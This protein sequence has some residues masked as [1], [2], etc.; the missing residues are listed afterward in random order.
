[1]TLIIETRQLS[2]IFYE[3]QANEV[4][5]VQDISLSVEKGQAVLLKG[6]SGSGKSTLLALLA[7][8]AK[9]TS[10]EYFCMNEAVSR[11]S[12][13]FLTRFRQQ[14][15]GIVFQHFHLLKGLTVQDNIVLPLIPLPLS[16]KEKEYRV[17]QA[18]E[19]AHIQH[20]LS[21]QV[22]T[23]SG[24]EMQRVAIARSL[25]NEP[26]ILLADEP[27]AHLDSEN[28]QKMMTIFAE[29]K[30]KGTTIMI[31]SHDPLVLQHTIFDKV[32]TMKDGQMQANSSSYN[33]GN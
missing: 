21:F 27:T 12:E 6:A 9:P 11:W 5:A 8:L 18:A 25:V 28:S 23:L 10:G 33:T 14:H 20:R 32:I 13:K 4:A 24:G 3:G 16:R 30:A 7:C 19:L 31:T 2:K 17:N 15:I 26:T 1:M 29:L 22:D